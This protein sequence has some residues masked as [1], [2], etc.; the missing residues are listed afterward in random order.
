V[1]Q[2]QARGLTGGRHIICLGANAAIFTVVH[3]VLLR[4]LPVPEPDRIVGLGDVYPTITPDDILSNDVPSYFDRLQALAGVVVS[5]QALKS[6]GDR[7]R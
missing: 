2:G 1:R 7:R 4:P 3:A 6:S 5:C